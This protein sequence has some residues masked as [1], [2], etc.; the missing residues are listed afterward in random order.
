MSWR[1]VVISKPSKLDLRLGCLVIRDS[2]SV[3]RIHLSEISVLIIENTATSVT[4]ALLKELVNCKIKVIFCDEKRN[5]ISELTAY[6]GCHNCSLK[7]KKQLEWDDNIKCAVWTEI[8][9]EKIKKQAQVLELNELNASADMLYGYIN[10]IEFNDE[11][12]REGHAAKVYFN[13]LFGKDFSRDD[14][15]NVINSALNYGYSLLLSCFNREV[16]CNG[17]LTQLGLFHDNMFNQYNLSCDLMEPFRPLV[18]LIVK[19]LLPNKFETEEKREI[20]KLFGKEIIIDG[21]KQSLVNGLKIY[22]K[23]VFDALENKDIYA[24]KFYSYDL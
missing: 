7:L 12:N 19:S 4:S 11:T 23:S 13:S 9:K 14:D 1:T 18:D 15:D 3:Q 22:C 5:P 20:L 6:Y 16:V 8:I 2:E 17:F 21:K 10:E 24:I